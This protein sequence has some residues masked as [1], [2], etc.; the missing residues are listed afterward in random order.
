[1]KFN[2]QSQEI[3][4][5]TLFVIYF[6]L[7]YPVPEPLAELIS[8]MGGNIVVG[9]IALSLFFL[10]NPVIAIIGLLVA[11]DLIMKSNVVMG[12]PA[13]QQYMPSEKQKESDL[14]K[15]NQFPYTL[16]QEIVALRTVKQPAITTQPSFKP[17]LESDGN[18]ASVK[19]I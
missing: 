18:A 9:L 6:I 16:E 2:M 3:L 17:M 1:M 4:L 12:K 13:M 5:G 11:V 8:S 7:G 14:N 19:D 15:F 10:V